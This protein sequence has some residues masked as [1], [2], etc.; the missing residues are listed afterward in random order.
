MIFIIAQGMECFTERQVC[1]NVEGNVVE[2]ID[3]FNSLAAT[4][5]LMVEILD[6]CIDVAFINKF[7]LAAC[8]F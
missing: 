2:P 6:K 4:A 7:L 3:E 1:H 8:S 5:D